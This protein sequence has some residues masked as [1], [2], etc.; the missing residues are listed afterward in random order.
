VA[1]KT[2]YVRSIS[3]LIRS[4][5]ELAFGPDGDFYVFRG[6]RKA[7]WRLG[8]TFA[9]FSTSKLVQF[10]GAAFEY[11]VNR[12]EE[13]LASIGNRHMTGMD[14]RT[15]LE[16]ARHHGVPSP[17]IDLTR[18]PFIALWFAFSGVRGS[19]DS[20]RAALYAIN[21]NYLA[22]AYSLLAQSKGWEVALRKE[23][24]IPSMDVFRWEMKDFFRDEYPQPVLKFIPYASSANT[25]VQRQMGCFLYDTLV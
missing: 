22:L 1:I 17:L 3:G 16:F 2:V 14:R 12:F 23:Y 15:R 19:V 21:W 10:R 13:G 20:G 8:S 24:K 6:H 25:K 11:L 9:R 5:E 18:S 4:V 7:C